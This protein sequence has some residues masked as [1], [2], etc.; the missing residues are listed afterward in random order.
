MFCR[1]KNTG[2]NCKA[3]A[4]R[5]QHRPRDWSLANPYKSKNAER[6]IKP[7]ERE[8]KIDFDMEHTNSN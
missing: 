3:G 4:Q 8:D 7:F 2:R 1:N 6:N 5:T